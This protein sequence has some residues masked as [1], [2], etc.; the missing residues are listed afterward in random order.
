MHDLFD[1]S[2]AV[3]RDLPHVRVRRVA[4]EDGWRCTYRKNFKADGLAGADYWLG[5]EN[6]FLLDFAAD[7]MPHV[8]ELSELKRV[9]D[10]IHTPLV[11]LLAT[12]D[13][14]LTVEDWLRLRPRYANGIVHAHPFTHAGLFL[15]LLR[16]CLQALRAVHAAGIVHCDVK[17]DNICLPYQPYPFR[18][19]PGRTVW[20]DFEHLRLIDFAF[21]VTPKR[22][23]QQPLPILPTA[24][25]QSNLLK[26]A[27][28]QDRG[29]RQRLAAQS[30]DWRADLYSLGYMAERIVEAGLMSPAGGG[31]RAAYDGAQRLAQR[32]LAFDRAKPPKNGKLPHDGLIAEID[33]LLGKLGDLQA[34]RRFE[35]DAAGV[36]GGVAAADP[37]PHTPV[38]EAWTAT[39]VAEPVA[40]PPRKT[41]VMDKPMRIG[42]LAMLAALLAW[43]GFFWLRQQDAPVPT[44]AEAEPTAAELARQKAEAQRQADA[45]RQQAEQRKK[46][47]AR[48]A[49]EAEARLQAQRARE[50]AEANSGIEMVSIPAGEFWMGSDDSNTEAGPRHLV[51]V[52]AFKLSKTEITQ[53]QWKAVMGSNPSFFSDCGD[54]CPVERVNID[55]VQKFIHRL[56]VRLGKAYRLPTEAE[57]E[58]ACRAGEG[59]HYCGGNNPDIVA[60][61]ADN[62]GYKIH[63]VRQK[64]ANAWGLYDM[65]GNILEWTCSAY[66][67]H[68]DSS[69]KICEDDAGFRRVVRGGSSSHSPVYVSS[70]FRN[71]VNVASQDKYLGFRL[72]QGRSP[73]RAQ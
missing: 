29:G 11:S 9:V 15:L 14:G 28:A 56:N 20:L 44:A 66:T 36:D 51:K 12:S 30:L 73:R 35:V 26:A 47:E 72:A 65:S 70:V 59:F 37:T 32:L 19:A 55:D 22:P 2:D 34:Y 31:G 67:E 57:W 5:R 64:Q 24:P 61:H 3:I 40:G 13:A 68:Y 1:L 41:P 52:Q 54:D 38:A 62:S 18:P 53:G 43:G 42:L 58:Y 45:A 8:Q 49:A 4:P 69:E 10:G 6:Q 7:R 33:A 17:Q 60:W 46:E 48:L 25:Y 21:S 39:P 27:L 16:A 71:W 63:P 23:L 50:A